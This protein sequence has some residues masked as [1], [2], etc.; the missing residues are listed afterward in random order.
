MIGSLV[1]PAASPRFSLVESIGR[2][3]LHISGK[4]FTMARP[5]TPT[6]SSDHV[7][8]ER[9]SL[10]YQPSGPL[11]LVGHALGQSGGL[12]TQVT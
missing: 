5:R 11:L 7:L 3:N 12:S 2:A 10:I 4:D 8:A 9:G 6:G 1:G